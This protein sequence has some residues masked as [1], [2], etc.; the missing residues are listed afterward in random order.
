MCVCGVSET[1][2]TPPK[3]TV[4]FSCKDLKTGT[5]SCLLALTFSF[6]HSIIL[7]EY[8]IRSQKTHASTEW[9]P[10]TIQGIITHTSVEWKPGTIQ[11]I[12]YPYISRMEAQYNTGYY[13][14]YIHRMEAQGGTAGLPS[15]AE[16]NLPFSVAVQ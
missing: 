11:G 12:I 9:K 7:V 5:I 13:Y 6:L 4:C 1:V 3:K 16:A 2:A 14:T 8:L 15:G 10:S